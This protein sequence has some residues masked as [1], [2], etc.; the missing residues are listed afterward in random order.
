MKDLY[1]EIVAVNIQVYINNL[2]LSK[3]EQNLQDMKRS[4][5]L[6]FSAKALA[7]VESL[8]E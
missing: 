6:G 8:D 4:E 7:S 3:I 1:R 5:M 2:A